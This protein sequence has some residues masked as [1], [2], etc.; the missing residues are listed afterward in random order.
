MQSDLK[1]PQYVTRTNKKCASDE[2]ALI[3][4]YLCASTKCLSKC[5]ESK[6][7]IHLHFQEISVCAV[8]LLLLL[9]AFFS[10]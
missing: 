2:F 8:N 7:N 4:S 3:W 9:S 1:V 10:I 5:R 6:Q